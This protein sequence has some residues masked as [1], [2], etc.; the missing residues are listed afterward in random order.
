MATRFAGHANGFRAHD[1]GYGHGYGAPFNAN[2]NN[3]H[4]EDS[5]PEEPNHVGAGAQ[6]EEEQPDSYPFGADSYMQQS[7]Q[8]QSQASTFQAT[9]EVTQ[10]QMDRLNS[11]AANEAPPNA[12]K[13]ISR[14]NLTKFVKDGSQYQRN[15]S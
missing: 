3:N 6:D 14:V 1:Y 13:P 12:C 2:Y 4:V 7:Q 10:S 5:Q 11:D 9:Q 15:S 8:L